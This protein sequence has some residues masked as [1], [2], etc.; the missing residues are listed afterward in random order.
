MMI[1]KQ[2][3]NVL[4]YSA[5][6]TILFSISI[7]LLAFD[8]ESPTNWILYVAMIVSIVACLVKFA[9][10]FHARPQQSV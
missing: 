5:L 1:N 6:Y 2:I 7:W 10:Q 8:N 4:V 9:L 3:P